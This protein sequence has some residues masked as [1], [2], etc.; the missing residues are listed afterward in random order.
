[1]E[2]I[3]KKENIWL[4]VCDEKNWDIAVANNV[5]G[6]DKAPGRIR[7]IKQGDKYVLYITKLGFVGWGDI[8]GPY[9][10][11]NQKIWED[12]NINTDFL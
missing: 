3:T 1:M 4:I 2:N 8:T 9:Y 7:Q 12:K 10:E 11:S 6:I 5:F